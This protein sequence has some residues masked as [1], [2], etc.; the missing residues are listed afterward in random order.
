MVKLFGQNFTRRE[1]MRRIGDVSQVGGVKHYL[2]WDGNQQGVEA[3]DFR[4]G[5]GFSFT[6]LPGRGM[7]ISYAEYQGKSLCWRSPT[8]EVAASYFEPEGFG[9]LRNF[10]AG[11][12]TTCG[13]SYFGEP[14]TDEGQSLGLH[15]RASNIPAR[16]VCAAGE[17][18]NDEYVMWVTGEI[19]ETTVFG[20]NLCLKR[21]ISTK[22]GENR[23]F[24][25]DKVENLGWEKT[26]LMVLYH[27]NGGYPVVD[28][29]GR[30]LCPKVSFVPRDEDAKVEAEKHDQFLPPTPHFRERVYYIDCK[31][32]EEGNVYAALVNK[33]FNHG[34]GFGFYIKYKKE[35]LPVLVE[36]KMNGEGHYVV[37]V[38]P[39]TNR[40]EGR[41][42]ERTSGT[43][44]FLEPGEICHFDLE[45]GVLS[46]NEEIAEF[47][48][49]INN[50]IKG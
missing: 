19:R 45:V 16:N 38:E 32:D 27:F 34:E 39:A 15:G 48:R 4:T 12:L 1:L 35:Q 7:D 6:V 17:W 41:H 2:L 43:L 13:L 46:S 31:P 22:L 33:N 18:Q 10:F 49:K 23:F 20:E 25:Q 21:K 30:L 3:V 11:L 40:V 44:K 14:C 37:G 5:T 47:E 50:V 26:P 24:I 28:G 42:K 8:G 9:W 36:W 29:G